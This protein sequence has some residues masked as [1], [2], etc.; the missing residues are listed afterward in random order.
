M[1]SEAQRESELGCYGGFADTAFAGKDLCRR[2]VE[3]LVQVELG[4]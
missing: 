2:W 1:T 4:E 3:V